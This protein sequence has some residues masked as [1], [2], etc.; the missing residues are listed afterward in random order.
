MNARGA[1]KSERGEQAAGAP[2]VLREKG[3]ERKVGPKSVRKRFPS[4]VELLSAGR[5]NRR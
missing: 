3:R 5:F 4:H 1:I 2:E